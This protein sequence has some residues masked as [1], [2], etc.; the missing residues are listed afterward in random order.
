[1]KETFLLF[2]VIVLYPKAKLL[3]IE[4][5]LQV[6]SD[7]ILEPL[8]FKIDYVKEFLVEVY[9]IYEPKYENTTDNLSSLK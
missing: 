6:I 4:I 9:F 8:A 2:D 3:K 7:N 1:M 5:L